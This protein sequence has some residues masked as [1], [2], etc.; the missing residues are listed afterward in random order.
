MWEISP[1]TA[2]VQLNFFLSDHSFFRLAV[3]N[4]ISGTPSL[5]KELKAILTTTSNW[6]VLVC[7]K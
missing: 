5:V 4:Q 7:V 3:I 2:C 6:T 1:F